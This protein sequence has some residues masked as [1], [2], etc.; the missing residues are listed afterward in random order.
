MPSHK[1]PYGFGFGSILGLQICEIHCTTCLT[2]Q[3]PSKSIHS[4]AIPFL[5]GLLP[6]VTRLSVHWILSATCCGRLPAS[7]VVVTAAYQMLLLH[8]ALPVTWHT[9]KVRFACSCS[10]HIYKWELLPPLQQASDP[11]SCWCRSSLKSRQNGSTTHRQT[12][13]RQSGCSC[14]R[15]CLTGRCMLCPSTV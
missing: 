6:A 4:A 11:S 2:G 10:L 14:S 13:S 8:P 7:A 1:T 5:Q 9:H 3:G 15:P 12:A